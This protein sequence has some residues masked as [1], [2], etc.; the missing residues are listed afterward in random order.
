MWRGYHGQTL[1]SDAGNEPVGIVSGHA[2]GVVDHATVCVVE[3]QCRV[4]QLRPLEPD[5]KQLHVHDAKV[6]HGQRKQV[7][8]R[9][10]GPHLA[11][12]QHHEI[13]TVGD[14]TGHYDRQE[15]HS[16]VGECPLQPDV[17]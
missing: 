3:V 7:H 14:G 6:S 5:S 8:R 13:E 1:Q 4:D 15:G 9:A 17:V 12:G 11:V 2:V 16:N 10:D